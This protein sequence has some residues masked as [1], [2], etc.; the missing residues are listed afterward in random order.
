MKTVSDLINEI[1]LRNDVSNIDDEEILEYI[2]D[3]EAQLT[4]S[5]FPT[6]HSLTMGL[7]GKESYDISSIVS[8]PRRVLSV[9]VDGKKLLRKRSSHDMIEGWYFSVGSIFLSDHFRDGRE[10]VVII[11]EPMRPHAIE[12]IESDDNLFVPNAYHDLYIF[13]TLSQ[14]AAKE[15]DE[16]SYKNYKEDY[17]SLLSEAI[18]VV[19][20]RQLSPNYTL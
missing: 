19:T 8:D 3:I 2:N 16:A 20:K 10:M 15:A 12:D 9:Y 18:A 6:Y 14:I 13:Y 1:R 5:L 7:D 11:K 17:N 4:E